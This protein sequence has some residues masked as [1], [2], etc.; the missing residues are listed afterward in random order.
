MA[1]PAVAQNQGVRQWRKFLDPATEFELVLLTD[2]Q[3]ESRYPSPPAIAVDRRSRTL[4][5]ASNQTGQWQPWLMDLS[6]GVSRQLGSHAYFV[7]ET[8][9][10]SANGRE[11]IFVNGERLMAMTIANLKLRTLTPLPRTAECPGPIAPS[12]DGTALFYV[13]KLGASWRILRH[14]TARGTNTELAAAEEPLIAPAPNPRRAMVLWRTADGGMETAAWDGSL[15]RR[16]EAPQ[17]RVLEAH[18]SPDGQSVLYL[19]ES[20]DPAP[21]CTIREQE[22]DSRQDRLVAPTSQFGR[23]TRNANASVFLGASRSKATPYILILLRINR[24][25]FSLC[26]HRASDVAM[27]APLFTPDS[28]KILFV[29]DRMGKPAI[30]LMNVDKLVE[31]TDS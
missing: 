29:S 25:E 24:R 5:Y 19:H 17:G 15:R 3:F 2:P 22:L 31:K 4:L 1:A 26:E 28:Q 18:W 16:L 12:A 13:E 20:A 21:R 11:A 7:P 30:F 27:V 8:L 6:S 23:F 14:D 9:T 10:L